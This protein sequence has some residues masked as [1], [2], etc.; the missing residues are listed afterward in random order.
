MTLSTFCDVVWAEIWD[1]CSPLGDQGKYREI[2]YRLFIKG[3][4]PHE[5]TY[6][7]ADG[8]TKS[9][10][11]RKPGEGPAPTEMLSQARDLLEQVRQAKADTGVTSPDDG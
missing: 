10:A 1:D 6:K 11:S 9:L 8:K 7:D 2:V 4:P 3:D 5:I